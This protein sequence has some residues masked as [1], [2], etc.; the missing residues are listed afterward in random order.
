M[1]EKGGGDETDF[2]SGDFR[3]R[4]REGGEKD[5]RRKKKNEVVLK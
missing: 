4:D 1:G 2:P 5:E 3:L